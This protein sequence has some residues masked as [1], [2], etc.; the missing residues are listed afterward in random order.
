MPSI[1]DTILESNRKFR[2]NFDGGDLSSDAGLLL[3]NEFISKIGFDEILGETFQTNDT[4]KW[5]WH[6]DD[7]NL[8]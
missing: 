2:V 1:N 5:R 6:T 8:I 3:L 4:A 7:E